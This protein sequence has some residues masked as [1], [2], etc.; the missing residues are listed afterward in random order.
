MV[1]L[2]AFTGIKMLRASHA[3]DPFFPGYPIGNPPPDGFIVCDEHGIFS[4][5]DPGEPPDGDCYCRPNPDSPSLCIGK[6][7]GVNG[8]YHVFWYGPGLG[9]PYGTAGM[10]DCDQDP[11]PE[12]D[13]KC[14]R[15]F[16][17]SPGQ[18]DG[19]GTGPGTTPGTGPGTA[20][21]P[22]PAPSPTPTP[23]PTPSPGTGPGKGPGPSPAPAPSPAP[24][25]GS[26]A[27]QSPSPGPAPIASNTPSEIKA[28]TTTQPTPSPNPAPT[29]SKVA[30]AP[31]PVP[32][33]T[34]Q[35]VQAQPPKPKPSPFY[36]GKQYAPQSIPDK[37]ASNVKP[38]RDYNVIYV[39]VAT[40]VLVCVIGL[41]TQ[42]RR[43]S[44][45]L[46]TLQ[47]R[48]TKKRL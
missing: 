16:G 11:R 37:F 39:V 27:S 32:T 31:N 38:I 29:A 28:P 33:P 15:V 8:G 25:P 20:P 5:T 47:K 9:C 2:V 36:D 41:L 7:I 12:F 22:A 21:S 3:E 14:N 26:S 23:T 42:I 34:A 1:A 35:G 10:C 48:K 4:P 24:S 45:M 13:N 6:G 18:G 44:T 30:E 43:I 46:A 17:P 19:T 40:A